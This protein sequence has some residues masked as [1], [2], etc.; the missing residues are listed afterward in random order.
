MLTATANIMKV[1]SPSIKTLNTPS[2]ISINA[3]ILF[4]IVLFMYCLNL[5]LFTFIHSFHNI[6]CNSRELLIGVKEKEEGMYIPP[7]PFYHLLVTSFIILNCTYAE[8]NSKK[9]INCCDT[10]YYLLTVR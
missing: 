10:T 5:F 4:L 9:S 2:I 8:N 7:L 3:T 1:Q 6:R